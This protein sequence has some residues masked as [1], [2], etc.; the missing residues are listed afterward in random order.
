LDHKYG[1]EGTQVLA[2]SAVD[3]VLWDLMGKAV[4]QPMWRLQGAKTS[5]APR[6]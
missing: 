4:D 6:S 5:H 2:I 1:F 3:M